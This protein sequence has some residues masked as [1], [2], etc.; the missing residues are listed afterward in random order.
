MGATEVGIE[1]GGARAGSG[2]CLWRARL[3]ARV[4]APV[5]CVD[6]VALVAP[7]AGGL[8]ALSLADG[9][10]LSRCPA[11]GPGAPGAGGGGPAP[12]GPCTAGLSLRIPATRPARGSPGA[13]RSIPDGPGVRL[14][15]VVAAHGCGRLALYAVWTRPGPGG[16]PPACEVVPGRTVALGSESVSGALLATWRGR[17]AREE[18][19]RWVAVAGT[20]DDRV[21]G[22][23]LPELGAPPPAWGG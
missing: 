4:F 14:L 21:V 2:E 6:G 12:L 13:A 18:G 11:P 16:L 15:E 8:V 17:P 10:V 5:S 3:G 9:A 23:A 22:V 19:G 1:G 7:Q 20:R